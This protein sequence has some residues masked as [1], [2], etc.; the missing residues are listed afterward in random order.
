MSEKQVEQAFSLGIKDAQDAIN[1]GEMQSFNELMHY[2]ALK[3]S[4][5]QRMLKHSY[6]TFVEAL[7][8]GEFEPYNAR[9][10]PYMAK[11]FVTK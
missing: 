1:K 6:G 8:K 7:K 2:H 4:G 10:D 5:D 3:K 9:E 11:Y